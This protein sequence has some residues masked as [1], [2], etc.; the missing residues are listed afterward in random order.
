L[1]GERSSAMALAPAE[2]RQRSSH[3]L[4][5]VGDQGQARCLPLAIR[6]LRIVRN[7]SDFCWESFM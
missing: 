6:C 1:G 4:D 2:L 7:V 3:G 5:D